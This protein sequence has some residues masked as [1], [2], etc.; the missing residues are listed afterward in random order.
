MTLQLHPE[1]LNWSYIENCNGWSN[2][3]SIIKCFLN[4]SYGSDINHDY[5]SF[6][7]FM[8]NRCSYIQESAMDM[9]ETSILYV[10]HKKCKD[11]III[12]FHYGKK[13]GQ[14]TQFILVVKMWVLT[15]EIE[16]KK[17]SVMLLFK[18]AHFCFG[19]RSRNAGKI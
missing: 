9:I 2:V 15:C 12:Y 18:Q 7:P 5:P 14:M 11:D 16:Q 17:P 8:E 13:Y 10:L 6:T 3:T 19:N 1:L 4:A